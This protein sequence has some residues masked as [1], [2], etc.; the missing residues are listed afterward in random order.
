MRTLSFSSA[1]QVSTSNSVRY[2][3]PTFSS[4]IVRTE[5]NNSH[6]THTH[7]PLLQHH[8]DTYHDLNNTN[9]ISPQQQQE[10]D[11][12]NEKQFTEAAHKKYVQQEEDMSGNNLEQ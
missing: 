11:I 1:S 3:E 4:I 9:F 7:D 8:N 2:R 12:R 6:K 5:E 10:K